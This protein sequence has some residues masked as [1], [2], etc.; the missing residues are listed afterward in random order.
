MIVDAH[1]HLWDPT[2]R[3]YPWM[4]GSAL[5]PIRRPYTVDD[6][7]Q[8]TAAAGVDRT[9]LVQTVSDMSETEEFLAAA[10]ASQGLI[11]GVVG[12]VYL[13]A[14]DVGDRLT[15]LRAGVG[16]TRL[17]GIRHQVQ[18]EPDPGWL[19]RADVGRG[20]RAVGAV[21]LVY[22]LLVLV[23]Q[24]PTAIAVVERHP[25]VRFVLDHAAK[26]PIAAGEREPWAS[27]LA[28]LA[29]L[30]NVSCKLSGL[31]TEARWDS[32]TVDDIRPYA[33]HVLDVF[34]PD[35]VL[36]GSDWPVCELAG[37]YGRVRELADKLTEGLS[38]DERAAVFGGTATRVYGLPA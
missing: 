32:W 27:L 35:R 7:R 34:G 11:A 13:T 10:E 12:W 8:E 9:V 28:A 23:P 4:S 16:G 14:D 33:E 6:L 37:S 2:G 24:L 1:H 15:R 18:D 29:V 19:R 30:P 5:A 21:G 25:D 38:A 31:V 22:D 3:E 26:P 36:W 17:V 20:L